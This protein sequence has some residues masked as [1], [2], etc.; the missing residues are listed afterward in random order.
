VLD[1]DKKINIATLNN[2]SFKIKETLEY[3]YTICEI[4][5]LLIISLSLSVD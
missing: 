1:S 3:L 5:Y 4:H 2:I